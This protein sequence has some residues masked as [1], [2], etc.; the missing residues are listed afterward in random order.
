MTTSLGFDFGTTNTVVAQV[1]NGG[2]RAAPF[3]FAFENQRIAAFRSALCFW[4]DVVRHRSHIHAEAGPWAI[5]RFIEDPWDCRF[6]QSIKSFAA[7]PNFQGTVI[8]GKRRSYEE[9]LGV[10]FERLRAH[11]GERL[12][13]L[14]PRL[15]VGRPITYVGA[16]PD[17]QLAMRRYQDALAPFGFREIRYVYEPVAAA[18]YYAQRLTKSATVLVAD[19]GGGTT[20]YSVMRFD[21]AGGA[22]AAHA[23]GH[24][25]VGVAGDNFDYRIIDHVVSPRLGKGTL[26]NSMGK[27][28]EIPNSYY[29]SFARWNLLSVMKTSKEFR[30]I[31]RLVQ[32]SQRPDLLERFVELIEHDHGYPLYKAVSEA[33]ERLSHAEETEFHFAAGDFRIKT[34]IKRA[35]FE[36]WIADDLARIAAAL[37]EALRNASVGAG[38]IDK[39]FLTGGT[40]FV[41]AVRRLF[42]ERFPRDW[43]ESGD[44]LLSIANGLALIGE[45]ADIDDWTVPLERA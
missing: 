38:D 31:K 14:P 45:Q 43:I 24:A 35:D 36:A 37:D 21:L 7:S 15:V 27:T 28:L 5:Q 41:P 30:D 22:I 20:D 32:V 33:K 23:L 17:G 13:A 12:D 9:L 19:F 4:V 3:E 44:E 34:R 25:G 11:A 26:Y 8:H 39:V 29:S 42:E 10:F 2:G 16:E 6:M 40:S 1:Q 18:F